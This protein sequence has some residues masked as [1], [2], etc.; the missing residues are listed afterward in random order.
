MGNTPVEVQFTSAGCLNYPCRTSVEFERLARSDNSAVLRQA[1]SLYTGDLLE[2]IET[3]ASGFDEWLALERERLRSLAIR[4]LGRLLDSE[5]DPDVA[6]RLLALDPLSE[7]AHRALM[8]H[9][10]EH[11]QRPLAIRQFETCAATLK[12][13]VGAQPEPATLRLRDSILQRQGAEDH[14]PQAARDK[15]LTAGR[16]SVRVAHITPIGQ[17]GEAANLPEGLCNSIATELARFRDIRVF[18]T[19]GSDA[20]QFVLDG[21]VQCLGSRLRVTVRLLEQQTGQQIWAERYDH[22]TEDLFTT[23]DELAARVATTVAARLTMLVHERA[24]HRAPHDLRAYECFVEGNRYVD[25]LDSPEAQEQARSWFERALQIE[26]TF[27]RAHTGLA[28]VSAMRSFLTDIGKPAAEHL[29]IALYHAETALDLD[30]T[31]PRVQYTL[32][33]VC[34][35]RREFERSER[36]FLRAVE[37]NPNDPTILIMWGYAQACVGHA[38]AGL[39]TLGVCPPLH[40]VASLLVFFLPRPG[41]G[42]CP[43]A[44]RE[45][46]AVCGSVPGRRSA[47]SGLAGCRAC[48]RRAGRG[49]LPYRQEVCRGDPVRLARRCF[50][51]SA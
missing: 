22:S 36:H 21:T 15:D 14:I 17:L 5:P 43:P 46:G 30:P 18:R 8:R 34:L 38:E 12:R 37:L 24:Q 20:A 31:D 41:S 49:G 28:F 3:R 23:Q 32:A 16:P 11:G 27:A 4:V 1:A 39:R 13:E 26:P 25:R 2:G 51:W 7:A 33:Y 9:Y 10:A 35:Q 6:H 48:S 45:R 40:A 44:G 47:Q 29:D 19:G 42:S 50:G